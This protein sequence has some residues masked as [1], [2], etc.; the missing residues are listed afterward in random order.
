MEETYDTY[1]KILINRALQKGIPLSASFELLPLCNMN[2]RMCYVRLSNAQMNQK[3]HLKTAEEWLSLAQQ[4]RDAGTLFVILTGGEPLLYPEFKKVYLGLRA[5]GMIVTV[6]TNGT[7]LDEDWA[8]FFAENPPRR[9]NITLYG[10]DKETYKTLCGYECGYERVV[11]ALHLLVERKIAVKING[12]LVQ[13][14]K[15]QIDQIVDIA[16]R[17]GTA[18]NVDTYMYP[19]QRERIQPFDRQSRLDPEEAASAKIHFLRRMME[20]EA[21]DELCRQTNG[22]IKRTQSEIQQE[23]NK[24]NIQFEKMHCQAGRTSLA[25]NWQGRMQPCVMLTNPSFSVLETGLK[26]AW[27]QLQRAVDEICLSEKCGSCKYRAVCQTCAAC[28]FHEGGS[29]D[30]VP[31][32]M[33]QYTKTFCSWINK[34][35]EK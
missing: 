3:G 22:L 5:L 23:A 19:A 30:A 1:E 29:F 33:C 27:R 31:A 26:E 4:M 14:N 24:H 16:N 34:N 12:S 28:A 9:I 7:L 10:T 2:C 21:F 25:V 35:Q 32:Y 8:E 15:R 13:A 20:A 17:F 18:V 6:N 11:H